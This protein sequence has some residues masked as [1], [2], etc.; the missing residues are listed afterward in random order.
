MGQLSTRMY[1]S[2]DVYISRFG[3]RNVSF[4]LEKQAHTRKVSHKMTWGFKF[5]IILQDQ[6]EYV[7]WK[8]VCDKHVWCTVPIRSFR[9]M[10]RVHVRR[11]IVNI[12]CFHLTYLDNLHVC[13]ALSKLACCCISIT[14]EWCQEMDTSWQSCEK[15]RWLCAF[16]T[17]G[18]TS[19]L[20][21]S[22]LV[23]RV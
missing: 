20:D 3:S 6:Y 12:H 16:V 22:K 9:S 23:W 21:F 15:Q 17:R 10:W 18:S 8:F 7:C 14:I 11:Y 4:C 2:I 19:F 1:S 13:S 5:L